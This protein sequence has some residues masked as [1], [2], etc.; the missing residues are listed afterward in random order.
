MLLTKIEIQELLKTEKLF[1]RPFLSNS[2]IG[3]TSIDFRLGCDFLVSIQGRGAFLDA[4][5]N[6]ST[7]KTA[8]SSFFQETRRVLGETFLLHPNQSV[9]SSSLEYIKMPLDVSA[10]LIMRSS[11]SRLGL[12]IS[13]TIQPGYCGC[14]SIELT[15]TGKS[16]INLT[17]GAPVF[18]A[19]FFKL[20]N[21]SNYFHKER[22][23][24]CQVRP[25]VSAVN[26]DGDLIIL[27]QIW[28]NNNIPFLEEEKPN[29][30]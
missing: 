15:N 6:D 25:I 13:S 14:I 7:Y 24:L 10:L 21:F 2:Q 4:N 30:Q 5:L 8:I 20:S 22:K 19:K 1:I 26:E 9:L 11:Y 27:N 29:I 23:Y 17:V 12:I 18:Q 16:P 28:K 3:E